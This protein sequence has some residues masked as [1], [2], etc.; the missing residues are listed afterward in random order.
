ME[1]LELV[2]I[3]VGGMCDVEDVEGQWECWKGRCECE[4]GCE[5]VIEMGV[6]E[7]DDGGRVSR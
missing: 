5:W 4:C 3:L 6:A 2:M 7:G 1:V